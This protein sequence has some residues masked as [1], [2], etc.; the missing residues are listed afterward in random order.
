MMDYDVKSELPDDAALETMHPA[1]VVEIFKAQ[2]V[3]ITTDQATLVQELLGRL[4]TIIISQHLR[5]CK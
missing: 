2:G 5:Q 3:D 1:K 4:S